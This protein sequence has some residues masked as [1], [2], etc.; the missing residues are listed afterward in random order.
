[1]CLIVD[2]DSDGHVCGHMLDFGQRTAD[3]M[4]INPEKGTRSKLRGTKPTSQPIRSKVP[5]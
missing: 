1:M 4:L 5:F 2:F 3:T